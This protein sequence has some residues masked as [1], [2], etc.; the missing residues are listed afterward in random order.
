MYEKFRTSESMERI[1]RS[2][3]LKKDLKI[4]ITRTDRIGDVVLSVP[5]IK[6]LR[7]SFPESCIAFMVRPYTKELVIGNPYLN[8]VLIYD[9]YGEHKSFR[10]FLKFLK[11]LKKRKFDLALIL[12]PTNRCHLLCYFAK[13]PVRIGYEIK[14]G[15]LNN[16][17][18]PH[19]KPLGL[20]HELEYNLDFLKI[21][22]IEYREIEFY[23]PFKKNSEEK[24]ENLFKELGIKEKDLVICVNPT[25]SCLSK[26]WKPQKF[27]E[28]IDILTKNLKAK[29]ILIGSKDRQDICKFIESNTKN[30]IINLCGVL[31]LADLI[32][33]LKRI[34]VFI[35]C[36][37]GPVHIAN[38]LGKK[39]VVIFGR[40]QPGLSPKRW[41]PFGEGHKILHKD[42]GC[43]ECLAHNC[44]KGFLCL[45]AITVDEVFNALL[46]ILSERRKFEK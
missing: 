27:K 7:E 41:A 26:I 22:G 29:V 21:L 20:K 40:K 28:L 34:T 23:L 14:M 38:A 42:V 46:E 9:K 11:E 19:L 4:L 32:S 1:L 44:K 31:N 43:K 3:K 17:K 5:L 2:L 18:L 35:S 25:A 37:S 8:E 45:E 10:G 15:F 36:D 12:H 33:L 16:I 24:I 13:I 6:I 30:K 39:C